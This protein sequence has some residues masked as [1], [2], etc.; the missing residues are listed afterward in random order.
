MFFGKDW[1]DDGENLI[2]LPGD[3]PALP[4]VPLDIEPPKSPPVTREPNP[5]V[6]PLPPD[7]PIPRP[8][9]PRKLRQGELSGVVERPER[10]PIPPPP[11]LQ[12]VVV[13]S[14][15]PSEPPPPPLASKA[16]SAS[17][18][19]RRHRA[20]LMKWLTEKDSALVGYIEH[21]FW[22][23][24][25]NLVAHPLLGLFPSVQ[26]VK[27]HDWSSN[28]LNRVPPQR[29]SPIPTVGNRRAWLEHNVLAHVAIGLFPTARTFAYHDRTAAAMGVPGWV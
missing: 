29:L 26:T 2:P 22:W 28:H 10:V 27:L 15:P 21:E 14:R 8:V 4:S 25:H 11:A 12:R 17:P 20:R 19:Q 13:E 18:S 16:S 9:P 24:V 5:R 6:E 7:H 1:D 3:K 23:Q